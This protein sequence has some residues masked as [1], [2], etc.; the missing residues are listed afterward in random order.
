MSQGAGLWFS[1]QGTWKGLGI[2]DHC[3][4]GPFSVVSHP[5]RLWQA[6][7]L[8]WHTRNTVPHS[9]LYLSLSLVFMVLALS[10]LYFLW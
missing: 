2:L 4:A 1:R 9:W 6:G 5:L 8:L 3:L 7:T 10:P